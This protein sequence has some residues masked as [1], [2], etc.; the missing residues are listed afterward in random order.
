MNQEHVAWLALIAM[1]VLAMLGQRIVHRHVR[2]D[3]NPWWERKI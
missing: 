3:P 2:K 1:I